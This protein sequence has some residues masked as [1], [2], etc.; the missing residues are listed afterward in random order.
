MV[1]EDAVF[2]NESC[3]TLLAIVFYRN[4]Y[5]K[6]MIIKRH[7][8]KHHIRALPSMRNDIPK[9]AIF[10]PLSQFCEIGISLLSL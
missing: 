2:D 5:A 1:F 8:L 4:L 10:Y 6:S 3:V 7:I 9:V